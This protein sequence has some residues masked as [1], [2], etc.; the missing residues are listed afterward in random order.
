LI[1]DTQLL[2]FEASEAPGVPIEDVSEVSRY[3]A[4]LN[5]GVARMQ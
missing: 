3:V 5:H 1:P 2:L 4:A